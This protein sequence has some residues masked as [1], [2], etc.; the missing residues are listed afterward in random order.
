VLAYEV[1]FGQGLREQ[2]PAERA[3]LRFKGELRAELKR[4]VA[5]AGVKVRGRVRCKGGGRVLMV[6]LVVAVCRF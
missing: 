3:V 6:V 2:G 5:K 1:V 4:R